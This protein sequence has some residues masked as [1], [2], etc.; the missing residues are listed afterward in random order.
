[1]MQQKGSLVKALVDRVEAPGAEFGCTYLAE[2]CEAL[3]VG[4][5]WYLC[6]CWPV[7]VL[8]GLLG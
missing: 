2:Y 4:G 7:C 8:G 1:M 3:A 6:V 5:P